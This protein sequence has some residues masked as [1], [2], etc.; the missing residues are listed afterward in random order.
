MLTIEKMIMHSMDPA[1]DTLLLSDRC[2]T[3]EETVA[4]MLE[5][6]V[7]KLFTSSR[8][9][10]GRIQGQEAIRNLLT[11]FQQKEMTF[12]TFSQQLCT[13]IYQNKRKYALYDQSNLIFMIAVYENQRYLIGLDNSIMKGYTHK[14]HQEGDHIEFTIE[15]CSVLSQSM[16]KKDAA[17]L[18][19][20]SD[21]EVTVIENKVEIETVKHCFYNDMI[22]HLD[23]PVSYHDAIHTM[24]KVC[25]ELIS[26]YDLPPVEVKGKMKQVIKEHV[27]R[28]QPLQPEMIAEA[29][30]EERPLVQKRFS[31]QLKNEGMEKAVAIEHVKQNKAERVQRIK[32]DKGIELIIPIDF[33]KTTDYVEIVNEEAGMIS[34]RLKNIQRITSK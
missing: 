9:K 29:V 26:A 7:N 25:D 6:K 15:L 24:N 32:T 27:E 23:A 21:F 17:F 13:Y 11:D 1:T 30:F 20:I 34:I 31:D 16:L 18:I 10:C 14:L 19:C 33:M 4:E 2:M 5:H 28:E 8:K 3:C 22:F 12:E